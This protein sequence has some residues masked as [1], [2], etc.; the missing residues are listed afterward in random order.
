MQQDDHQ[1]TI[2]NMGMDHTDRLD[3]VGNNLDQY[4]ALSRNALSELVEQRDLLKVRG[5]ILIWISRHKGNCWMQQTS[6]A[7]LRK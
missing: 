2:L 1:S 7:C 5:D 3:Q 6:L 4:I